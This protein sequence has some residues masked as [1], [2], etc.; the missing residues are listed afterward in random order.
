MRE[1]I[2][3]SP[4]ATGVM[5]LSMSGSCF[6]PLICEC[7]ISY[8]PRFVNLRCSCPEVEQENKESW[9]EAIG[10][11]E[12]VRAEDVKGRK[13]LEFTGIHFKPHVRNCPRS[14]LPA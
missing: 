6:L 7:D 1:L 9:Q 4:F 14:S 5:L 3:R 11:G 12:G 2:L 13:R 8:C 10:E